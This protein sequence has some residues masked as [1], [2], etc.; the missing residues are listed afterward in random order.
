MG[1]NIAELLIRLGVGHIRIAD[2]DTID[3]SNLNRQVIA[4]L[5]TVGIGKT[6]ASVAEL[7]NI[8]KDFEL[9]AYNQGI[10]GDM[11]EEFVNGLD[12]VIDEIDVFPLRAHVH[13]QRAARKNNLPI[14]SCYIIGGGIRFYKFE[15]NDYTFEDFIG[16]DE[17]LWDNPTL[18]HIMNIFADYMPN[19]LGENARGSIGSNIEKNGYVPIF[20]PSTQVGH[21]LVANRI[22]VDVLKAKNITRQGSLGNATPSPV[23]PQYLFAD[24]ASMEIKTINKK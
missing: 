20:G 12:I 11:A 19:Y 24:F 17:S 2:P 21:G 7:R 16:H 22:I 18:P 1:S 9:V 3:V 10:T 13:L 5:N 15:G 8:A 14:Y 4:N 23:M 6:E